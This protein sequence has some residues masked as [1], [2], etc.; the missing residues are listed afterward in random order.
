MTTHAAPEPAR[1]R[2]CA[3][4][5]HDGRLALIRRDRPDG[6]Q[7]SLPGGL[8]ENGEDPHAALRCELLEELG[9]DLA[10]LPVP[11]VLRFVQDQETRR[12]GDTTLV[13]RRHMVFTA[14]LPGHV[15][16]TVAA[17]EQDDPGRAPVVWLP[18]AAAAGLHL[19]PAVGPVLDRAAEPAAGP[20][21]LAPMT[22]DSY[23]WR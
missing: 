21:L 1:T 22:G 12:L 10:E 9:L 8:I 7:Y 20:V 17:A 15:H 6:L 11:P 16:R 13:R 4:L 3:I 2:V 14:H 5:L 18:L 19:Y 23:W